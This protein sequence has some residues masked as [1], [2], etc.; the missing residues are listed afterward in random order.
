MKKKIASLL[1]GALAVL[2]VAVTAN[3]TAQFYNFDVN[4]SGWGGGSG[5]TLSNGA[6][7]HGAYSL[8]V[9]VDN[10][11]SNDVNGD[12]GNTVWTDFYTIPV[13]YSSVVNPNPVV[14]PA[15]TGQFYVNSNGF[16]VTMSGS[17]GSVIN[18]CTQSLVTGMT[19]PTVTQYAAFYHVS[20]FQDYAAK[21]WSLF[22]NNVPLAENLSF[23]DQ[24][25]VAHDWFQVQNFGGHSTNVCW[26]DDF[27]LTNAMVT[28]GGSGTNTL[29]AVIPGTDMPVV[30]AIVYFGTTEPRPAYT[31]FGLAP[32]INANA[33]QLQFVAKPSQ[34]YV[35]VGGSSPV[36]AMTGIS[37]VMVDSA[38]TSNFIADAS[39]LT[40]GGNQFYKVLTVST[41]DSDKVITNSETYAWF[42]QSRATSNYWYWSGV[43]VSYEAGQNTLAGK[44]GQQL[45]QGLQDELAAPDLLQFGDVD[46]SLVNGRWKEGEDF[47]SN[48]IS[49]GMG[50]MI[51]RKGGAPEASIAV[52]SGTWS[53]SI[54][55][56]PLSPGWNSLIWP[57]DLSASLCAANGFPNTTGDKIVM[58][59]GGQQKQ[60][61]K[62]AAA[63]L[64]YPSGSAP[65]PSDWPQAGE[66]F[67]YY[68]KDAGEKS[69][70][71][72]R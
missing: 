34:K 44:A 46:A 6:P 51:R 61:Q 26:L 53:A 28:T 33:V 37:T 29:T 42:K 32:A 4:A 24:N 7:T 31:N 66:G 70:A 35:L 30:D 41:V 11:V 63:W 62:T 15:A 57:Y 48:S 36:G 64:N 3:A 40:K 38:G 50:V 13:R 23:I 14:D 71:P 9:P 65:G 59:R 8:I 19:Y 2:C 22:V 45:A 18:V 56:V 10:V 68:N 17:G 49:P 39:A 54:A 72:V 67:L 20:V 1:A 43:P 55:A 58:Q 21:K 52:L 16:W 12:L 25:A 60:M 69:W 5:V 27:L 47:V